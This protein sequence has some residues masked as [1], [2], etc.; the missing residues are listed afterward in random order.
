[1]RILPLA[2]VFRDAPDAELVPMAHRASRV[3]HG[4]P[5]AQVACALYTLVARCLLAGPTAG[6]RAAALADARATLRAAYVRAPEAS[7][8]LAA[9]DELEAWAG[10]SGRGFVVDSFW[11]ALDA[12]AGARS[13]REAI[14]RAIAYGNDTDTTAAITGGLAG[15]RWGIEGIPAEWLAGLRGRPVVDP[16]VTRLTAEADS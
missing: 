3:T 1:M 2:L 5:A 13:Y 15:I 14:E 16:L 7:A 9:L 10:R 12:F 4:T 6:G 11:S 8:H